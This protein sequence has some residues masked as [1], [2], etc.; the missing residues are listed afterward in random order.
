MQQRMFAATAVFISATALWWL[1]I[2]LAFSPAALRLG[3]AG[4]AVLPG[5]VLL[6][7]F[8]P[9][10]L[11]GQPPE[12]VATAYIFDAL[13]TVVGFLLFY[14]IALQS[15]IPVAPAVGALAYCA[16]WIVLRRT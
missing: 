13:G 2:D 9:L 8:F 11:R 5:A 15:G 1:P 10:G 16:A 12:A 3:V 7:V 4:V 14:L 6:G